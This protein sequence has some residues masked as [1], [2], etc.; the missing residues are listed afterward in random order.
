VSG[1]ADDLPSDAHSLF[2]HLSESGNVIKCGCWAHTRRSFF[3]ALSSDAVR[4]NHAPIRKLFALERA[5]ATAPP[6]SRLAQ[7]LSEAKP[8]VDEFFAWCDGE[9]LK[10]LDET[11]ISKA[12]QYARNQREAL[13]QFLTDGRRLRC[14]PHCRVAELAAPPELNT[15]DHAAIETHLQR[16]SPCRRARKERLLESEERHPADHVDSHVERGSVGAGPPD[17]RQR[18][19]QR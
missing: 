16:A 2:N 13:H 4:G 5:W 15:V 18:L 3:K 9:A 19:H 17:R 7:R 11:P 12:I 10:V 6:E 1:G 14:S 8:L